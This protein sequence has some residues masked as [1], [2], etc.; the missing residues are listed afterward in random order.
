MRK[1]I[2]FDTTLRDG[3]QSPGCSMTIAEKLRM[4]RQL[5]KMGVDV[6]EAG[7]AIASEGDFKAIQAISNTLKNTSVASLARSLPTDIDRAYQAIK[8]GVAPRIH[9]F[10]ATSDIHLQ[11]K[12]RMTRE[13]AIESA[14]AAVKHAKN[15]LSDVEFSA[16]DATRSDW[17]Y[18]TKIVQAVIQAGATTVNIPDTVGYTTPE[19]Y[20]ELISHLKN[21]VP[22]IEQARISV[23]CHNDL[24]MGVANSWAAIRAGADQVECTVNGIGERA[25]NAALEEIVMAMHT[26]REKMQVECGIVTSEIARSSELLSSITGVKVQP[27]KA[28]VGANA[29]AHES[30]IHQHGMLSNRTTYEIMTPESVGIK[31]TRLVLGKHSGKHALKDRIKE[32]GYEIQKDE[33]EK[34]FEQFK[35]LCD[36]K[37]TIYDDDLEALLASKVDEAAEH[38]RLNRFVINTGNDMTSTAAVVIEHKDEVIE[39]V[40]F[41][42]GPI[43]AAYQAIRKVIPAEIQLIEYN[44]DAVTG[45]GDAQGE[46]RLKLEIDGEPVSGRGVS[47]D[48]IESSIKAFLHGVNRWE[49]R[50]ERQA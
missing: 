29:F 46:V 35:A 10:I 4:A 48:I 43:D 20:F 8:G 32:L 27:H 47:T 30:G 9:T 11:H 22:N 6:L 37:K 25:G 45:G 13:Q 1:I 17:N 24:G 50:K 42:D 19:E 38:Y 44:I 34:I 21:T 28:I 23:H 5:E 49:Q 18:L 7:F 40:A 36:R 16:E 33:F 15:Y 12:L 3:E 39:K 41:G 2:V 14:V 26:R 31:Q